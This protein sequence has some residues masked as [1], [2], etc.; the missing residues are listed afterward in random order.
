MRVET[1]GF[2]EWGDALPASGFEVFHLPSALEVIDDHTNGECRLYAA[3]KGQETIGLLPL[4]L[5]ERRVGQVALSPPP[6]LS[7][8]RLGPLLMPNSPKRRKREQL[9]ETLGEA[10][11]EDVGADESTSLF[12]M[13]CPLGYSD[14]R[15]YVWNELSVQPK[16]TYVVDIADCDSFEELMTGFSKSLRNK[17]RRLPDLDVTIQDE[18]RNG[19]LRIYEEVADRYRE[20]DESPPVSRLFVDDLVTAL[21]DRYRAYVARDG[22]ENY[23]GGILTLYSNDMVYF[24]QGG[25]RNSY[26]GVSVNTLLHRRILEDTITDPELE[27]VSGYDLVGANTRRLCEYK[28]KFC[29]DLESYYVV[30][31][32]SVGMTAAKAAYRVFSGSMGKS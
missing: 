19:A 10:V 20:Q 21:D 28:A 8:P 9:N 7:I 13:G 30:E 2:D 25:V 32:D 6:G 26:D 17:M 18:H 29:G 4:F 5:Q 23:L 27:T 14:P 11:L 22:N 15:P 1:I 31:S 16:F 12:R 3:K 24:W